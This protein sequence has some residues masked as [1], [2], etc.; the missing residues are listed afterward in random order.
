MEKLTYSVAEAAKVLGVSE[1]KMYQIVR[2]ADFPTIRV[3]G[4]L[5]V[6]KKGLEEWA[7]AQAKK[8]WY[9]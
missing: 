4:R 2:I 5:L 3:G 6:H 7:E 9:V 1:N 8:G